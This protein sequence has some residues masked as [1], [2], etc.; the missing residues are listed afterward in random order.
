MKA[1][2]A[3]EA[4][5]YIHFKL[6]ERDLK[7]WMD[8]PPKQ[9]R[10]FSIGTRAWVYLNSLAARRAARLTLHPHLKF[11]IAGACPSAM[12]KRR[13]INTTESKN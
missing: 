3:E 10:P 6:Y 8:H 2:F 7:D 12:R 13:E 5:G 9:I 1:A 4:K 11:R